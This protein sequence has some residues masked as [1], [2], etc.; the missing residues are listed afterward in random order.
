MRV[1]EYLVFDI[2]TAG[3]ELENFDEAQQAYLLRNC[4][5]DDERQKKIGEFALSPFTSNIVCIGLALVLRSGD[6]WKYEKIGALA[7]DPGLGD[8]EAVDS[9]L[10]DGGK[11]IKCNE[12]ELLINFWKMLERYNKARLISFNGRGFDAPFLMLRSA[13]CGVRPCRNLMDGTKFRY[14]NHTDLADE[15]SFYSFASS[16]P[17]RRFNFDF[18]ARAFGIKSPKSEGVDGSMVTD[19]YREGRL[20]EICEYCLRDVRA[21]WE[22]FMAWEKFLDFGGR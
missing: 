18:Y 20:D 8:D 4:A 14:Y 1:N 9:E 11:M 21:T 3:Q 10:S 12:K 7:N 2:E 5:D 16:G 15:L 22:L 6:E 17:Q 13:V 19:L